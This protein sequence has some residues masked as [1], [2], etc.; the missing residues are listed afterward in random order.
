MM[1]DTKPEGVWFIIT[2]YANVHLSNEEHEKVISVVKAN[3]K[4]S[5][6]RL[7]KQVLFDFF[8]LLAKDAVEECSAVED[9]KDGWIPGWPVPIN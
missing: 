9:G 7:E 2:N 4:S 3:M 1:Y 5:K 8:N 6:N